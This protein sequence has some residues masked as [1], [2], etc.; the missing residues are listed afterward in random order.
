MINIVPNVPS[1]C[2]VFG[3]LY[4]DDDRT[5]LG[6]DMVDVLLPNGI[7][8]SCGWYAEGDANGRYVVAVTDRFHC[9]RRVETKSV[10]DARKHV[11]RLAVAFSSPV[12]LVSD[13]A[14]AER[15]NVP[16]EICA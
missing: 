4:W 11:E 2:R 1:S 6:E 7:L 9:L 12:V 15:T 16:V 13:S 3:Q 5:L 8:V 14:S 10:S